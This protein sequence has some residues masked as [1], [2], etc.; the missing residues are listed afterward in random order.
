[1]SDANA[2]FRLDQASLGERLSRISLTIG[3]GTTALV[4]RS[5]AGKS[6]LLN[7][8]VGLER[9]D[10]G[11]LRSSGASL[12]WVPQDFGLWHHLTVAEH[13]T[14]VGCAAPAALLE[15]FDIGAL[16]DRQ[17]AQLSLGEQARLAVARALAARPQVLVMDEPLAQIDPARAGGYWDLV[18]EQVAER[19]VSLIFASHEPQW[20]IGVADQLICLERGQLQYAGDPQRLYHDPPTEQLAWCLGESNWLAP[21]ELQLWLGERESKARCYRP[22]QLRVEADAAGP[23]V[24]QSSRFK[25]SVAEITV[26]HTASGATR[27]FYHR[28]AAGGLHH[29]QRVLLRLALV[30]LAFFGT[31]A[32]GGPDAP[33]LVPRTTRAYQL[34]PVGPRMPAPRSLAIGRNGEL[35]VLD[36]EGRVLLYDRS[37]ALRRQW[38]MPDSKVGKPE[39]IC[40][41]RDG[42]IVVAD[43]HYSRLVYFDDRGRVL[44]IQGS[45]GKGPGQFLFP[46]ALVE[47]DQRNLY[48]C[49]YGGGDRI[50]K[51]DS[52]GRFI[53]A[54]GSF[55][56]A[57]GQFQRPSG[58]VWHAGRLYVADAINNR[59]QIFSDGG[60]FL[61]I[62]T[63]G[64]K[65]PYDIALGP[66]ATLYIV[67]YGSGRVTRMSLAGRLLGRYGTTGSQTGQLRTPWGLAIDARRRL[68]IADTGN[69]RI[70]ELDL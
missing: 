7:L 61:G 65:F 47:D 12:F 17:P 9:P 27:T 41:L 67:E 62:Y 33:A 58:M 48:V 70:V 22:E 14:L 8:L 10:A 39:G 4:G 13:L 23:L 15:S 46:V 40:M 11:S 20:V 37:G 44:K 64:L 68:H 66:Q 55:G 63:A 30:L 49:E 2:L 1:V 54:F 25:G 50:Q 36:T 6:S 26:R 52:R 45:A 69:R 43:T 28:P 18:L 59:I 29:G 60:E 5:G 34:P 3:R 53:K 35:L 21:E 51:F 24:V 56:T 42:R 32:C 57:P 16:A 19:G 31:I 38:P